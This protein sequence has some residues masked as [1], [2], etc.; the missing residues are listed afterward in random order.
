MLLLFCTF[1]LNSAEIVKSGFNEQTLKEWVKGK[2]SWTVADGVLTGVEKAE[3]KHVAGIG[4]K[5]DCTDAVIEFEFNVV[6]GKYIHLTVNTIKGGKDTR[7]RFAV[8]GDGKVDLR[9]G[10]QK[11]KAYSLLG[12]AVKIS[13]HKNKWHSVKIQ[14]SGQ[15]IVVELDGK[16]IIDGEAVKEF[17]GN[18]NKINLVVNGKASFRNFKLLSSSK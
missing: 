18:K 17:L 6:E 12:K 4:L 16:V 1:N 7:L 14:Y 13:D 3:D 9:A 11:K 5:I 10:A 8:S 2:G 15:E